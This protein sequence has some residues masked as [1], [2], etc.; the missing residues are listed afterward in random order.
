MLAPELKE[1]LCNQTTRLKTGEFIPRAEA[2]KRYN[3][4]NSAT[5]NNVDISGFYFELKHL[6]NLLDSIKEHN[7]QHM[8]TSCEIKGIRIWEAKTMV[9]LRNDLGDIEQGLIDDLLLVPVVADFSDFH[10]YQEGEDLKPTKPPVPNS[11]L[12]LSSSRPCPNLCGGGGAK[13]F[14][15]YNATNP[16][17]CCH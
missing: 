17:K 10:C 4:R 5:W 13:F 14:Y 7:V 2:L 16:E 11:L 15:N 6:Q 3:A 12:I 1:L 9:S 8:G